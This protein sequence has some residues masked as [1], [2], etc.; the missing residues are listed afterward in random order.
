MILK[1]HIQ[2]KHDAEVKKIKSETF[3]N[4]AKGWGFWASILF[5]IILT[6]INF[7]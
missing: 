2:Q 7:L 1:P 6:I 3:V 5:N 4:Y